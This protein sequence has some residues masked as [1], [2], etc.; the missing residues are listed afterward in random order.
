MLDSGRAG[1]SNKGCNKI[2]ETQAR[3][4]AGQQK[5]Q[6]KAENNGAMNALDGLF[7]QAETP[8]KKP[9]SVVMLFT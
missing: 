3:V 4:D 5:Q 8:G 6:A 9:R 7:K 1:A 2:D